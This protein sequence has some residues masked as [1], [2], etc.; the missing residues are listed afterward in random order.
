LKRVKIGNNFEKQPAWKV[1]LG[2]PLV[3]LPIIITIPF[4]VLGVIVV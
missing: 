1:R 4:V 3:Y 2:V